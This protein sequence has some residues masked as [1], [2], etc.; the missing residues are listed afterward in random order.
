M[1]PT[2]TAEQ[3]HPPCDSKSYPSAT[4]GEIRGVCGN[5]T[6]QR[7][8]CLAKGLQKGLFLFDH[9]PRPFS[10]SSFSLECSSPSLPYSLQ[11]SLL[12][13]PL[14]CP[15]FEEAFPNSIQA[16]QKNCSHPVDAPSAS[17]ALA[18]WDPSR[19][20]PCSAQG[21]ITWRGGQATLI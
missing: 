4:P 10:W 6:T 16:A 11:S 8:L 9:S 19:L 2:H 18:V 21:M 7:C 3:L 12:S 5:R 14:K 13:T 17:T 15:L 1:L 20:A